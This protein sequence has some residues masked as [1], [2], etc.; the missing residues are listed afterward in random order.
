MERATS[1]F[2]VPLSPRMSTVL[3][4]AATCPTSLNTSIMEG[5]RPINSG[6]APSSCRPLF[7][8]SF[9]ASAP[10][11][12]TPARS[13]ISR[14]RLLRPLADSRSSRTR[15]SVPRSSMRSRG[16]IIIS[17]APSRMAAA[18]VGRSSY[19]VIRITLGARS[20]SLRILRNSR[21]L[22]P[23]IRTSVSTTS[24]SPSLKASSA[25][26]P[27]AAVRTLRVSDSSASESTVRI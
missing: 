23:G 12:A 25:A 2:P 21:P 17:T 8:A 7:R 13:A 24:A 11:R 3:R 14:P 22:M 19:A 18:T 27:E 6:W 10:A 1:S 26:S 4:V 16:L 15:W 20:L 5:S 9:P